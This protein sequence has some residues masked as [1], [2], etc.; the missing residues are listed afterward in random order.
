[1]EYNES[2]INGKFVVPSWKYSSI[3]SCW[4]NEGSKSKYSLFGCNS[5]RNSVFKTTIITKPSIIYWYYKVTQL[6]AI[7]FLQGKSWSVVLK[8][9]FASINSIIQKREWIKGEKYV[10]FESKS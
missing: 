7:Q 2:S 4:V 9:R 5:P 3:G 8:Q 10:C 6:E 1:M